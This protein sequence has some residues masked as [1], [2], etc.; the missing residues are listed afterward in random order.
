MQ[1]SIAKHQSHIM[2][3]LTLQLAESVVGQS[4]DAAFALPAHLCPFFHPHA[5]SRY[6]RQFIAT[7]LLRSQW[8]H[9]EGPCEGFGSSGSQDGDMG[10]LDRSLGAPAEGSAEAAQQ[11]LEAA[12]ECAGAGILNSG[13]E[14]RESG[15]T[16]VVCHVE[17]GRWG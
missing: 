1:S 4:A 16:A 8:R 17:P 14:L 15:S 6:T 10:S 3:V 12:F 9:V 13:L 11:L 7:G 5:R 2:E